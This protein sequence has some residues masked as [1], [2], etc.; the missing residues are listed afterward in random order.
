MKIYNLDINLTQRCTFSCNYCFAKTE[1]PQDF[2]E[3]D[4][5]LKFAKIFLESN[6]FKR[7]YDLLNIGFWGGEPTLRFDIMTRFFHDYGTDNRVKFMIFSN[8]YQ[9]PPIVNAHMIAFSKKRIGEH[10]KCC[11]QISYD[12]QPLHDMYRQKASEVQETIKY[13]D[14]EEIPYVLKST[15]PPEGFKYMFDAYMDFKDV[16][17][18]LLGKGF[19][20]IDYFPTIDYYNMPDFSKLDEI[21]ADLKK[22]LIRI[23]REELKGPQIFRWFQKNRALCTAGINMTSID[24]DGKI[25]VCHGC[26]YDTNKKDHQITWIYDTEN[27]MNY[28]ERTSKGFEKYLADSCDDCDVSFCLRCNHS[29]YVNSLK[30]E[31]MDRWYDF[32][33]QQ[34]YLCEYYKINNK[35]RIAF[36]TLRRSK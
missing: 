10:P 27:A 26:M 23:A 6:F 33:S 25:Y 20:N 24:V 1:N 12:G 2:G 16:N 36:E 31:Y 15:I 32:K 17:K 8:G 18:Q 14:R 11:I 9:I 34:N 5:L 21:Y 29:K 28:I 3:I 7:N 30:E 19:K 22:S 4:D 35:V 13:L